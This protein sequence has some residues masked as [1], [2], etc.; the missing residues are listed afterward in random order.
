LPTAAAR[1][2]LWTDQVGDVIWL[3]LVAAVIMR[4][5]LPLRLTAVVTAKT[6]GR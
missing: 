4:C 5:T 1:L 6:Q 2:I 3:G